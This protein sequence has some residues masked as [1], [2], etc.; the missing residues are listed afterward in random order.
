M[1]GQLSCMLFG[2]L[3]GLAA[4]KV[5][6]GGLLLQILGIAAGGGAGGFVG[7]HIQETILRELIRPI[8]R[9]ELA[10]RG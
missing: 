8:L 5:L 4:V 6:E 7:G 10:K 9:E 2:C 1:L 3:A